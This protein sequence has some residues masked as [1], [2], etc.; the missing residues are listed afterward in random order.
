LNLPDKIQ[1]INLSG[2]ELYLLPE[3][4]LYSS[5]H[6]TLLAADIHLGKV[7]HFRLAGIALPGGLAEADLITLDKILN[8]YD[9]ENI[10]ILGDL[11]HSG[12][13]YDMNLF[14]K[15]R[16]KN[17]SLEVNLVKGN[18]DILSDEIYNYFNIKIYKKNYMW[19]KILLTHQ[20]LGNDLELNGCD[21]VLCG[22]VHPAV[23]LVGKG[24]Q[25]IKLPCFF[26]G[27]RQGILPAFGAFTGK[28]VLKP[29][30]KERVYVI[31]GDSTVIYINKFNAKC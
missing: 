2:E 26:F 29:K 5:R 7:G 3:K 17:E 16:R 24:K 31:S 6:K 27:E 14:A 30:A 19:N 10:M 4:A 9:I 25:S 28:C 12:V 21:Y 18:H 13:N 11:F 15:W 22:H 23:R 20:P 1:S 8:E